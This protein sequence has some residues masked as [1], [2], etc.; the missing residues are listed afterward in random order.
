M[1]SPAIEAPPDKSEHLMDVQPERDRSLPGKQHA[2]YDSYLTKRAE[3]AGMGVL[4]PRP[5][6]G[7]HT[8]CV[9]TAPA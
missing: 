5:F 3:R 8:S 6:F 7:R 9:E 2:D 1:S 4:V